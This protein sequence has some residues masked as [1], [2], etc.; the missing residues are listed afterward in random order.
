MKNVFLP[1]NAL[2][3]INFFPLIP[4]KAN[5]ID[6]STASTFHGLAAW[7]WHG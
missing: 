2:E 1:K 3:Y 4:T 6:K 7:S 5:P